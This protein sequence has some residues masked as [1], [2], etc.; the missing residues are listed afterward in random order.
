M[1]SCR[2]FRK[3]GSGEAHMVS[4][5]LDW[6]SDR[7]VSP[8]LRHNPD[9]FRQAKRTAVFDVAFLFWTVVYAALFAELASPRC[10]LLILSA[11]PLMTLSLV[12]LKHGASASL[13]GNLLTAGGWLGLT[14]VALASGGVLS[15]ALLWYSCGPFAATYTAGPRS[16]LAWTAVFLASFIVFAVAHAFGWTPPSDVPPDSQTLLYVFVGSGLILCQFIL[17]WV[18][19]G[20]ERRAG[21]ALAESNRRLADARRVL[22]TLKAGFGFSV[23]EW[24]QLK[25]EK[26]ALERIVRHA[27]GTIDE[28]EILAGDDMEGA[29][30]EAELARLAEFDEE[31]DDTD[32]RAA[33]EQHEPGTIC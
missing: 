19:V 15:P 25:R 33:V 29:K 18:R 13:C 3:F 11:V 23:E 26:A 24:Q 27:L 32:Q 7:F 5:T 10:G 6:V 30:L 28:D 14:T 9:V 4:Q 20:A 12:G 17:T 1:S 22:K 8:Q 2:C 16:G 21:L 31:N